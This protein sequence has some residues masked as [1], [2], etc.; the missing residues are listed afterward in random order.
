M[1]VVGLLNLFDSPSLGNLTKTRTLASTSFLGRFTPM[2]FAL[3]N[4]ANSGIDG[5]NILIKDNFRSVAK[6]VGSIKSWVNNTKIDRQNLLINEKG[7]IDPEENT[8]INCLKENDWVLFQAKADVVVIQ[9]AHIISTINLKNIVRE[10]Y[11][12]GR[13]ITVVYKHITDAKEAFRGS[14]VLTVENG[15]VVKSVANNGRKNEADVSLETYII[16]MDY[17]RKHASEYLGQPTVN[18]FKKVIQYIINH[19]KT[20]VYA[21]EYRHYAR[22]VDSLKHFMEYSFELF[23]Y[24]KALELFREDWPIYTLTHDTPP[25]TYGVNA[26]VKNSFISN[27]V[28]VDGT[29]ENS[30]LSRRVVVKK[31]AVV[32]NS[33]ILTRTVIE[34]GAHIE[35]VLI[36]KYSHVCKNAVVK[37][38]SEKPKFIAQ[39]KNIL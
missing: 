15:K 3:S 14:N 5:I 23:D 28:I 38:T 12:K 20:D 9:P 11:E 30:V 17:I 24:K 19:K 8:D 1:K 16:S 10:H 33:I 4:F 13:D 7:M 6:H 18:S 37:G 32:K 22:C 27:G 31:G 25:A 35:N 21:Y 2:D 36:D 29:V 26:K 34:E 39:G